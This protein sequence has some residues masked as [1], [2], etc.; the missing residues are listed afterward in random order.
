[1]TR[2]RL[3]SAPEFDAETAERS[4]DEN[5]AAGTDVGDPI[6][7][8]DEN[9]GDSLTYS[10]DAMGDMYFDID[11]MGQITVGEGAMLDHETMASHT[12]TVTATD[13]G[14]LYAM[15]TVTI[16]VTDVPE[17]DPAVVRR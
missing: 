3:N 7:A 1:M 4:V 13:T 16:T 6:V 17:T 9:T 14:R 10:L 2:G 12:V 11:D 15:I 8:T 5:S